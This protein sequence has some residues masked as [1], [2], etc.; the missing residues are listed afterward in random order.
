[1]LELS[2]FN[3]RYEISILDETSNSFIENERFELTI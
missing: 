3:E 2:Y 1:M